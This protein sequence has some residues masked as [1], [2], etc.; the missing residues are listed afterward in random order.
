MSL[1]RHVRNKDEL[2]ALMLEFGGI[3]SLAAQRAATRA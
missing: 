1:Y 3:E 2:V